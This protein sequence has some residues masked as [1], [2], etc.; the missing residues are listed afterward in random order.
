MRSSDL[1]DYV[2][3]STHFLRQ[4][5]VTIATTRR[6]LATPQNFLRGLSAVFADTLVTLLAVEAFRL[7][8]GAAG[9]E[10]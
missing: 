10:P 7:P 4:V 3:D 6:S 1:L 8:S 2:D 9:L 5:T